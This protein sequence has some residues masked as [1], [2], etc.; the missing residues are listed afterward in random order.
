MT[1]TTELK[2]FTYI[3]SSFAFWGQSLSCKLLIL[4]ATIIN[5]NLQSQSFAVS[6]T[7]FSTSATDDFAPAFYKQGL[8]YCSNALN[9]SLVS[10]KSENEGLFNMLYVQPKDSGA[11]QTPVLFSEELTTILNEGPATFTPDDKTVYYARNLQTKGKLRQINDPSNTLGIY[12]AQL[13][14]G[15]WT[16]ITG[17]EYNSNSYSVGTPALSPDAKQLYFASDMPGGYGGTDL[18]CCQWDNNHWGEPVNL[19][20]KINS[21]Y[22]ESYP[23]INGSGRIF[24][25]S[26]KPGGKGGKDIYYSVKD[27]GKWIKPIHLDEEIN[28]GADDFGLIVDKNFEL[29]Y[30]SST[31]KGPTNIYAFQT[32]VPQF[33]LCETQQEHTQCFYFFDEQFKDTLHV[34]YE[35]DFGYGI[36][37]NGLKVKQC[38][39]KPGRY[40]AVL[41]IKHHLPDSIFSTKSIYP[42]KILPTDDQ[43]IFPG[44]DAI[45]HKPITFSAGNK[46][47]LHNMDR[48]CFWDF[49][50]GFTQNGDEIR[51]IFTESGEQSVRLGIIERNGNLV[52]PHK[53]CFEMPVHV[54]S[55]YEQLAVSKYNCMPRG[56]GSTGQ[57]NNVKRK[58][59]NKFDSYE[60]HSYLLAKLP[61]LKSDSISSFL[62]SVSNSYLF[63]EG[64]TEA[65]PDTKTILSQ[66]AM[67]LLKNPGLRLEACVH[68]KQ[69]GTSKNAPETQNI[70][71]EIQRFFN[72]HGISPPTII[73][74]EYGDTRP[75]VPGKSKEAELKNKRIEFILLN[76]E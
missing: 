66:F 21:G 56:S 12:S 18:Y 39:Q 19:G 14:D 46:G 38:F 34:E 33:D 50:N 45:I 36:K 27:K 53:K 55:D 48:S 52:S 23:F 1:L 5:F 11:W 2:Y 49:G 37:Q 24:F 51:H 57:Q 32:I 69:N 30:F 43:A 16:N 20:P 63:F 71:H 10:I 13:I 65:N 31:R 67:L 9:R 26:D 15:K 68:Q 60:L 8:V 29:G 44:S 7:V 3:N 74:K 76:Q 70:A 17:F 40:A 58:T 4:L 64:D 75:L 72:A 28:S 59:E 54:F 62:L 41:T 35:W 47:T 22:N 42:F 6:K 25:A 73:C 61:P